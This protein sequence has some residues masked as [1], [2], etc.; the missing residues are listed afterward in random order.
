VNE[1]GTEAVRTSANKNKREKNQH[2]SP[3]LVA[4]IGA[5][6]GA[7]IF[8]PPF[9]ADA[10]WRTGMN[11]GDVVQIRKALTSTYMTPSDS[12]RLIQSIQILEQNQ[13]FDDA[14]VYAKELV[15]LNPESFDAWRIML[16][17]T[18]ST[19]EEKNLAMKEMQ[20]LDP[21]NKELFTA[22]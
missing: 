1:Q 18:K 4:G 19:Q 15:K 2:F 21:K 3:S 16:T 17:V 10:Q 11:K 13:L 8:V 6:I 20:K 5:V 7:L 9:N 22:K 14:Y 12:M